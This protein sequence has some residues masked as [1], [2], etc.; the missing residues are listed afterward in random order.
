MKFSFKAAIGLKQKFGLELEVYTNLKFEFDLEVI[1]YSIGSI[2]IQN[3][4]IF[5]CIFNVTL[6]IKEY[7]QTFLD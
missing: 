1:L 3:R 7:Q 4:E 2:Q 6:S 5:I